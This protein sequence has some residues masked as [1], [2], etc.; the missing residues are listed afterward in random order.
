MKHQLRILILFFLSAILLLMPLDALHGEK[1]SEITKTGK[2]S[3]ALREWCEGPVRYIITKGE[4]KSFRSLKSD[5]ERAAFI[6]RFWSKRDPSP[7]TLA[8]EFRYSFWQRV[9]DANFLFSES[10]KPGWKTDRGKVYIIM[11]PPQEIEEDQNVSGIGSPATGEIRGIIRW[12]YQGLERIDLEPIIVVAFYRDEGGEFRLSYDPYLNSVF[13][14]RVG[15]PLRSGIDKVA[16]EFKQTSISELSVTLDLGELQELPPEEEI[17]AEI[18]TDKEYFNAIPMKTI[19]AY[20]PCEPE[21]Q[22]LGSLTLVIK[23][24]DLPGSRLN[25]SEPSR[26]SLVAKLI[27]ASSDVI[28]YSFPEGSFMPAASNDNPEDDFLYYQLKTY[29]SPGKYKL[30]IGA[31]DSKSEFIGSYNDFIEVPSFRGKDLSLSSLTLIRHMEQKDAGSDSDQMEPFHFGDF[32]VIPRMDH[33]LKKGDTFGVFFQIALSMAPEQAVPEA[34]PKEILLKGNYQFFK[35]NTKGEFLPAAK[36]I[37]ITISQTVDTLPV[38]INKGWSTETL[39]WPPGDY[40]FSV[41]LGD[42]RT[43]ETTSSDIVFT[44][45]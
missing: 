20:Y 12:T 33:T 42:E 10:T 30:L 27:G 39:N 3:G 11:G 16:P 23:K 37:P 24:G 14:S 34:G 22:T 9:I 7:G 29:L 35:K 25:P 40:R 21:E 26:I 13:Y 17:F 45:E 2:K 5:E 44:I 36:P 4:E 41:S 18:I 6:N 43:N 31:F 38:I 32:L 8:N 1:K 19:Q 15:T 28:S